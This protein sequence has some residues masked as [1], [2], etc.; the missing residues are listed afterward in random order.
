[1][2]IKCRIATIKF[3]VWSIPKMGEVEALE[4]SWLAESGGGRASMETGT[5]ANRIACRLTGTVM[6]PP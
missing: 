1:M 6:T 3:V 5:T 2:S 4:K